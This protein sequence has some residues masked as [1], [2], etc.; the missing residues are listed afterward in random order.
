MTTLLV[1]VRLRP[2]AP[3]PPESWPIGRAALA[4]QGRGLEVLVGGALD[5]GGRARGAFR[6]QPG[7]WVS[8]DG[9]PVDA[10]HDRYASHTDPKG[11]RRARE[12]GG[13]LPWGNPPSVTHLCRDKLACQQTLEAAGIVCPSVE[14]DPARFPDR[15]QAW[16]R[17]FI[18]PQHGSLGR[19]VRA[20]RAGDAL[21]GRG[22]G[23]REG[24]DDALILQQ[25]IEPPAGMA[26]LVLRSLVQRDGQGHWSCCPLVAR[27]SMDDPVVNVARRAVATAAMDVCSAATLDEARKLAVAIAEALA[28]TADD[29]RDVVELGLDFAVDPAGRPWPIEVNSIPRGRLSALMRLDGPRFAVAHAAACARPLEA[30]AARGGWAP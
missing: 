19:G 15:L 28:A 10:I 5:A 8:A 3:S 11:W 14:A 21:A 17:A 1:L 29:P 23:F 18:K 20:V 25:A 6:A 12:H 2:G 27:Y 26:G 16:G 7:A 22:T 9:Q 30:M 13:M 24:E 4:L